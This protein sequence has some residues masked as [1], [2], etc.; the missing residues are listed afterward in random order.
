MLSMLP[1]SII[2]I[3]QFSNHYLQSAETLIVINSHVSPQCVCVFIDE[4]LDRLDWEQLKEIAKKVNEN[5][6]GICGE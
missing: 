4:I 3:I 1:N 5:N 6:Q 2:V